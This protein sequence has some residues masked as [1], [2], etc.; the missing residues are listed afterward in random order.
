MPSFDLPPEERATVRPFDPLVLDRTVIAIP[1]LKQMEE[2]L[3]LIKDVERD[4]PEAAKSFN[5]AIKLIEKYPS[6]LGAARERVRALATEE[7]E[8]AVR[9]SA[10]RLSNLPEPARPREQNRH[11]ALLAA[12][13][14]QTIEP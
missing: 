6:G 14:E 10:E 8:Q 5:T 4:F 12:V 1:L 9:L 2:E 11:N 13:A 3:A 7:A